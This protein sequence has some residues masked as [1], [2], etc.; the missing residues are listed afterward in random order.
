V[1]EKKVEK[2]YD[3]ESKRPHEEEALL[4]FS[5][6]I[7]GKSSRSQD[8]GPLNV[9]LIR[10]YPSGIYDILPLAKLTWQERSHWLKS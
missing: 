2:R 8:I 7:G 1:K 6:N 4:V 5:N 10:H 9:W 3:E